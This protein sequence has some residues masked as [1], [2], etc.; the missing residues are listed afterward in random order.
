MLN[1]SSI[2]RPE[3]AEDLQ[4][5]RNSVRVKLAKR[6]LVK[7]KMTQVLNNIGFPAKI[8]K[9]KQD[10]ETYKKQAI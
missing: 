10:M 8:K 1:S 4:I 6:V 3:V 7:N 5:D 2:K 9:Y